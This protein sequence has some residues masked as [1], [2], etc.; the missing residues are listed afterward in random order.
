[1][2]YDYYGNK[3]AVASSDGSVIIYNVE[4]TN[5][6][7]KYSELQNLGK[8]VMRVL[9]AHPKFGSVLATVLYDR[10]INLW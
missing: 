8:P 10:T 6:F 5:N 7:V 1:M 3:L 4:N 9:W 2:N